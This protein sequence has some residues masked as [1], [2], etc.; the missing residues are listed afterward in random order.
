MGT[1]GSLMIKDYHHHFI[2]EILK[3]Y[4]A[5]LP[6]WSIE[7]SLQY[8]DENGI[9]AACLSL[10]DYNEV[11]QSGKKY[12]GLCRAMNEELLTIVEKYPQR[13]EGFAVIPFPN[14][15][16]CLSEINRCKKHGISGFTLYTN[17]GGVYPSAPDHEEIFTA[18]EKTELPIF[19][20]P[21]STPLNGNTWE[22]AFSDF[23]EYPQEVARLVSRWLAEDVFRRY[24]SLKVILSHGGGLFPFQFAR[25]GKLPYMRTVGSIMKVRWGRIIKDTKRKRT[26]IEDYADRMLFDLY[27]ADSPE[28]LAALRAVVKEK[29][30]VRGSNFPYLGA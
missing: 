10:S 30:L 23:I 15:F 13:F 7:S 20:H 25:L 14:V 3:N 16:G 9:E 18:I 5:D 21:A 11:F 17:V 6:E 29:Q 24:P 4:V 28:Q 26:V 8:M 27:D 1:G 22:S 12:T 19:I 2:P